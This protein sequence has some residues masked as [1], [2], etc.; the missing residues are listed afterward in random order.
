[1]VI[2]GVSVTAETVCPAPD[3]GVDQTTG[4]C[5]GSWVFIYQ[6]PSGPNNSVL[7]FSGLT[8]FAFNDGATN[9]TFG[10]LMC[11]PSQFST[12][13][14]TNPTDPAVQNLNLSFE[15]E[16]GNLIV[17]VPSF[18]P[19]ADTLTFFIQENS[20]QPPL[21]LLNEVNTPTLTI[22]GAIISPPATV[23]GSQ[24]TGASS[25]PQTITFTN[26]ADFSTAL[27]VSDISAG[28]NFSTSGT[29]GSVAPGSSCPFLVG[30]NP[31]TTGSLNGTFTAADNSPFASETAALSGYASTPGVSV[32]PANLVFGSQQFGTTSAPQVVTIT[33]AATSALN[34]TAITPDLDPLTGQADFLDASDTCIGASIQPSGSCQ[35]NITFSPSIS[36]DSTTTI[37]GT[38]NSRIVVHDDSVD[39]THTVAVTGTANEANTIGASVSSLA[40]GSQPNGTASAPQSM[41]LSTTGTA[42]INLV[43]TN[44]TGGFALQNDQCGTVG[45]IK[46]T[47]PCTESITFNPNQVGQ[48]TG[49]VT[50]AADVMGATIVVP[51]SG[52]GS[53]FLSSPSPSSQNVTQGQPTSYVLTLTPQGGYSGSLQFTCAGKPSESTCSAPSSVTLDGVHTSQV[54]FNITT[55]A[56]SDAMLFTEQVGIGSIPSSITA[57][58]SI[59]L[60]LLGISIVGLRVKSRHA[61][62]ITCVALVPL[63]FGLS[64]GGGSSPP[65]PQSDP[66]T[67]PGSYLLTLTASASGGMPSHAVTVTLNV[68]KK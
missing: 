56:P 59:C 45:L 27:N 4:L 8:K 23:F 43:D 7:T 25:S 33:N 36:A 38:I 6:V 40:F 17:I 64:C 10:M 66:G 28:T 58:G 61:R 19:A 26:P 44:V 21:E 62:W 52:R 30:F 37:S 54:T 29:C 39:T 31:S 46:P 5:S 41:T 1:M 67:L 63:A 15:V 3:G 60:L 22:G 57:M 24:E 12:M 50:I 68:A 14:C 13:L 53:D 18:P 42:T 55:T 20:A 48:Y 34:I 65:P 35:A 16:G 2:N 49:Y 11:D 47:L 32:S 51:L 9:P